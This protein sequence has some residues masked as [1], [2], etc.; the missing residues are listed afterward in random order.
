MVNLAS[1]RTPTSALVL[2]AT[3]A[4]AAA[5]WVAAARLMDG[6]DMGIATTPGTF[7]FFAAAWVAMTA[8]MMLPGAAPAIARYAGTR[9]TLSAATLFAVPYLA[10]WTFAGVVAFALD[11]PHGATVAG[12]TVIAAGCYELTP[13]KRHFR[14]RCR[15]DV[16]DGLGYGL[17]C[18]GS[19]VGLM[20]MLVALDVMSLFWMALITL[21]ATAQKLLTPK[22]AIDVPLALALIGLGILIVIAPGTVPGTS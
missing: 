13:V 14:R 10:V 5:C 3:F 15:E 18:V 22:L 8:A 21:L 12:A 20:A 1:R 9:G 16:G 19:T 17:C 7:G 11:R 6:M 2:T 4:L